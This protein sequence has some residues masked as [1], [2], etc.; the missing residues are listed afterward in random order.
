VPSSL[1]LEPS[2]KE[3]VVSFLVQGKELLFATGNECS[4][5][6]NMV[7]FATRPKQIVKLRIYSSFIIHMVIDLQ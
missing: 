1:K 5:I 6:N 7:R 2:V 3:S 4:R